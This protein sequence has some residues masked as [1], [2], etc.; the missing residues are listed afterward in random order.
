MINGGTYA[1]TTSY[2]QSV[3]DRVGS[4]GG[5]V[6]LLKDGVYN[7]G[8]TLFVDFS[9]TVLRGESEEN[10]IIKATGKEVRSVISL[11]KSVMSGEADKIINGRRLTYSDK[12][13]Q[14]PASDS[15]E[16]GYYTFKVMNPLSVAPKRVRSG[17]IIE[18]FVPFGRL[19]FLVSDASIFKVGDFVEIF[20]PATLEWIQDIHMDKIAD[21][22]GTTVQW[23]DKVSDFNQSYYRK[24]TKIKGNRIYVDAPMVMALD[25]KYGP[26]YI[27]KCNWQTISESGIENLTIDSEYDQSLVSGPSSYHALMEPVDE[28]HAWYGIRVSSSEHCWVRNVTTRHM[29]ISA[30]VVQRALY[31]TVQ[32]CKSYDPVSYVNGGRRYAFYILGGQ[33]CLFRDCICTHDRHSYVTAGTEGPNVF[34]NCRSTPWNVGNNIILRFSNAIIDRL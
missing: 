18:E 10:T 33:M 22:N 6:V 1:D 7:V 5:G 32:N 16:T 13:M 19:H 11:G 14:I 31:L 2:L 9:N 15:M 30:V 28:E 25:R 24:I 8:G 26:S 21:P 34:Y 12:S 29:G 4:G 3:I 23:S 17:E 27:Y 20:R